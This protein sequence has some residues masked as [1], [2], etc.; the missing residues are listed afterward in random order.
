[1]E[2]IAELRK[3]LK[4]EGIDYYIVTTADFHNSEYGVD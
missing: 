3:R 1:M 4:E 2:Q